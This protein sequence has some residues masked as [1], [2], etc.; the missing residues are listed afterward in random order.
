MGV[1]AIFYVNHVGHG[2]SGTGIVKLN[3]TTKG[4]YSDWS[5]YT[6]GGT[7]EITTLNEKA[8]QWF[9][10]RLGKDV[11][12]TFGDPTEDDLRSH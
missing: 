12:I 5:K 9:Y 3:A 8:T 4:P 6:P 10:E 1:K 11:S 2:A 7:V